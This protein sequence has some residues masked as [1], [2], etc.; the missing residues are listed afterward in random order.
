MPNFSKSKLKKPVAGR[1]LA[2]VPFPFLKFSLSH[3]F[4]GGKKEP[5][6]KNKRLTALTTVLYHYTYLRLLLRLRN[7][8]S[9]S[10]TDE[11]DFFFCRLN[12]FVVKRNMKV[13][14]LPRQRL[15]SRAK[16]LTVA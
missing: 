2:Q 5:H 3:F 6:F 10:D 7:G 13:V 1:I 15:S 16:D 9:S 8:A 11:E 4:K 12:K 14:S